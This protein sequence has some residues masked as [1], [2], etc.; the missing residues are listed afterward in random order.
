MP[1]GQIAAIVIVKCVIVKI[2]FPVV[3]TQAKLLTSL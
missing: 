3:N 2:N 1:L